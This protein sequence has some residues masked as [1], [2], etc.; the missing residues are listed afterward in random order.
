M[1]R[2]PVTLV[3]SSM[4][5]QQVREMIDARHP[6]FEELGRYASVRLVDLPTG[7]W[8]MWSRT[9]D[10]ADELLAIASRSSPAH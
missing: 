5:A 8:P 1:A 4:S 2:L 6:W 10:L 7:H 3:C 9:G